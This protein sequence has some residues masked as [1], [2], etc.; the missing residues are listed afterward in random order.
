MKRIPPS[1]KIRQEV[2]ECFLGVRQRGKGLDRFVSL[3]ARYTPQ[4]AV[5][6]FEA[7]VFGKPS[8]RIEKN[9]WRCRML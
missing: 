4:V 3:G 8:Q 9:W 6:G 7:R 2:E 5:G 1:R